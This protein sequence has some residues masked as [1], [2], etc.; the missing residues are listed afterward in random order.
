MKMAFLVI[1]LAAALVLSSGCARQAG[2]SETAETPAPTAT[3][4]P[5]PVQTATPAPPTQTPAEEEA[6][7]G[8]G[9]LCASVDE[10]IAFCRE[11]IN[12]CMFY[13]I[14]NP[15]N[16]LCSAMGGGQGEQGQGTPQAPIGGVIGEVGIEGKCSG[17]LDRL[18]D[19]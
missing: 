19:N 10:C 8:L 11:N 1:C 2:T 7:G 14:T 17:V 6:P 4:Q 18:S 15:G 5:T 16:E 9:D 3:P 13:C 12:K